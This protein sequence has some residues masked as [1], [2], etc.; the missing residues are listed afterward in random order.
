MTVP[1]QR[2]EAGPWPKLR[3]GLYELPVQMPQVPAAS[4]DTHSDVRQSIMRAAFGPEAPPYE[5]Q[6]RL[7]SWSRAAA[8][9]TLRAIASDLKV[10][11][12]FQAS[13]HQP[14]LPVSPIDL[15]SL[16]DQ[17]A[18]EGIKKSSIDRLVASMVRLHKLLELPS[19][20]DDNLRWKQKEIRKADT[21]RK[22]QARG[23]RLKGDVA[24]IHKDEPHAISLIGLLASIPSDPAGLRDRALISTAYD[25]G[26][27][28]SEAVRIKV[29]HLERLATG[30]ASL[31]LP[32]SKTDQEG[33]GARA[34]LS[35]RSVQHIEAWLG[36]AEID[37]GYVFR[38]LSYRVGGAGHLSEGAVSKILKQRLRSYLTDLVDKG[39]FEA[40]AVDQ[41]VEATSAHSL[42]VGCDQDLFAAGVD[43]GAIMQG[44]RW[45]N[46]KQPLAYARHLAPATSKL[47]ST[48]RKLTG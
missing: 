8:P 36:R 22:E 28:R 18:R 10:V 6:R 34:W 46:P 17:R 33:E 43:I 47:A 37:E 30:E 4:H 1:S 20:V 9:N 14:T 35:V 48:M 11:S 39:E 32:R 2:E 29:E 42:R 16:I 27:R 13:R 7:V 25:A 40:G 31:F 24:D 41:I 21:R 3:K 44:L 26:L 45:T 5:V 38:P 12:A 15:Y 19:P 23:L